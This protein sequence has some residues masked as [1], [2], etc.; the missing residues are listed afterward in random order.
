M[1]RLLPGERAQAVAQREDPK[2][3]CAFL[4]FGRWTWE[5]RKPKMSGVNRTEYWKKGVA[6]YR[7]K[8]AELCGGPS[9]TM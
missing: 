3:N 2:Q 4:E 5:I 8:T 6:L 1:S 9:S 7:E